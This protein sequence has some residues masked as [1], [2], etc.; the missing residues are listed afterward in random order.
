MPTGTHF[1]L[2]RY[3]P[4]GALGC[5][6][7]G[8][9]PGSEGRRHG[10]SYAVGVAIQPDGKIVVAGAVVR[11]PT[12]EDPGYQAVGLVRYLADGTLDPGFGEG[13]IRVTRRDGFGATASDVALQPG[14]RILVAAPKPGDGGA[15]SVLGYRPDGQPDPS[16]SG[17]G[18]AT[19]V[20]EPGRSADAARLPSIATAA[21]RSPVDRTS[22]TSTGTTARPR[23]PSRATCPRRPRSG[24]RRRRRGRRPR[25]R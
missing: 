7:R 3:A 10:F 11:F 19:V 8:C 23:S 13:G 17:D 18:E 20:L 6:L 16:F 9:G 5:R 15:F 22:A 24:V 4:D 14:G 21:S 2:A 25:H 12:P 1:A